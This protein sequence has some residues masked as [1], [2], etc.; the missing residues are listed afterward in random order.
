MNMGNPS[1]FFLVVVVALEVVSL[2]VLVLVLVGKREREI[3]YGA[4]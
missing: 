1:S 2:E 4:R 3:T